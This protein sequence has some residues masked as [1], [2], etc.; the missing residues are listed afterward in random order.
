[1]A[2]W[3]P[4]PF[5]IAQQKH[6]EE[7]INNNTQIKRSQVFAQK[8]ITNSD[9]SINKDVYKV[10]ADALRPTEGASTSGAYQSRGSE[11]Q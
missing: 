6:S 10:T 4:A 2:P 7:F 5:E 1:V 11:I 8:P 3:S 9:K